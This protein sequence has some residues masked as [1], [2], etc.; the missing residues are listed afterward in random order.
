MLAGLFPSQAEQTREEP[1]YNL[2]ST[3]D[4]DL[5]SQRST[6]DC[7][8]FCA[9]L[10]KLSV[11][12][13]TCSCRVCV[14]RCSRLLRLRKPCGDPDLYLLFLSVPCFIS[15]SALCSS[16]HIVRRSFPFPTARHSPSRVSKSIVPRF[17]SPSWELPSTI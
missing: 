6:S 17:Q 10:P 1:S 3:A 8:A 15:F 14:R 11:S 2:L 5:E 16:H 4:D 12:S 9:A 13:R 7:P